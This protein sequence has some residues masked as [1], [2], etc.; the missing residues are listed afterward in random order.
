VVATPK[1]K[2]PGGKPGKYIPIKESVIVNIA[3]IVIKIAGS[4]ILFILFS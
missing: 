3:N 2:N 4:V 1:R